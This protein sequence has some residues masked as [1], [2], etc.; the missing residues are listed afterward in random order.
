MKK[1]LA[2]AAVLVAAAAAMVQAQPVTGANDP[3]SAMPSLA[4]NARPEK[5][6]SPEYPARAK[7]LEQEGLVM[8]SLRVLASG[9][10]TDAQVRSSSGYVLLDEAA[11]HYLRDAKFVPA[12]DQSGAPVDSLVQI[13]VSFVLQD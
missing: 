13:P 7:R 11:L 3:S 12:R 9:V 10:V 5:P 4:A 1:A 6:L 8:V 2:F